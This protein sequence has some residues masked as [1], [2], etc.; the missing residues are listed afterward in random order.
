MN[1][2][3]ILPS[4]PTD[5]VDNMKQLPNGTKFRFINAVPTLKLLWNELAP[6]SLRTVDLSTNDLIILSDIES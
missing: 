4:N 6:K 3:E 2:K 5:F 1:P